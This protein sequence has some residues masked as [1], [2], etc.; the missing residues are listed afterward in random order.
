MARTTCLLALALALLASSTDAA[1][2]LKGQAQAT[3]SASASGHG[4]SWASA[5]ASSTDSGKAVRVWAGRWGGGGVQRSSFSGAAGRPPAAAAE[6]QTQRN[7]TP[8]LLVAVPSTG[9]MASLLGQALPAQPAAMASQPAASAPTPRLALP[10]PFP[11]AAAGFPSTPFPMSAFPSSTPSTMP[12]F[13]TG[14]SLVAQPQAQPFPFTATA[15][16]GGMPTAAV[17]GVPTGSTAQPSGGATAGVG[18]TTANS[19]GAGGCPDVQ[20]RVG[21]WVGASLVSRISLHTECHDSPH[22][23]PSS[24]HPPSLPPTSFPAGHARCTQLRALCR[25]RAAP[26]L[27]RLPGQLCRRREHHLPHGPQRWPLRQV[28]GQVGVLRSTCVAE[29]VAGR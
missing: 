24:P 11:P 7:D 25:R 21:G 27:V 14:S 18:A 29:G 19:N 20:V 17:D 15:P 4:A 23:L 1:R 12:T 16:S 22:L 8:P 5:S 26:L 9:P 28:R 2:L 6:I 10:S 13:P 3:S